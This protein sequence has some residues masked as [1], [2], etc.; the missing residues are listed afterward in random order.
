MLTAAQAIAEAE[1]QIVAEADG[2]PVTVRGFVVGEPIN[3]AQTIRSAFHDDFAW[4]LADVPFETAPSSMLPVNL[5]AQLR[6]QWG[7][8]SNPGRLGQ[9]VEV[10]GVTGEYFG[11]PGLPVTV[12]VGA[13]L[14][15]VT[16]A[17]G[18]LG[19]SALG[20]SDADVA[21]VL[22]AETF[23]QQRVCRTDTMPPDLIEA[24]LRRVARNLRMRSLPL[25]VLENELGGTRVG[26]TDPE[27][28]RLEAPF[29]KLVVG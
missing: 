13:V 26:S 19:T 28:R 24:L 9:Q 12:S 1:A 10:V 7:L 3:E 15:D 27:I 4:S 6:A 21:G 8:R 16:A 2:T 17:R 18:Y 29:R 20:Y 14:P 11:L 5:P 23:A 25:A 22:Q